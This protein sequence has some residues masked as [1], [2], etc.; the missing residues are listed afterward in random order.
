MA[1]FPGAQRPAARV[2]AVGDVSGRTLR[3]VDDPAHAPAADPATD[4]V[5][6]DTSWTPGPGDRPDVVSVR[7]VLTAVLRRADVI[8]GSLALLDA[9][10]ES[11]RLADRFVADDVTWWYR[12]RMM[13]RWDIHELMLWRLVL[14]ELGP[15]DRYDEIVV[16]P[17]RPALAAAAR[18]TGRAVEPTAGPRV[19]HG[20]GRPGSA[21][22]VDPSCCAAAGR[23]AAPTVAPS[24][25][26][27]R[28]LAAVGRASRRA[29]RRPD[30]GPQR[31]ARRRPRRRLGAVLPGHPIGWPRSVRR[32][33]SRP[34]AGPAGRRRQAGGHRRARPRSA[35][36]GRLAARGGRRSSPPE[37]ALVTALVGTRRRC[38]RLVRGRGED[39][40]S[41]AHP[42]RGRRLGPRPGGRCDR[43]RVRR[44]LARWPAARDP[45]RRA[46]HAGAPA[47]RPVHRPRRRPDVVAGRGAAAGHPDRGRPARC[48]LPRQ[49]GVLPSAPPGAGPAGDDLPVR[50]VR[51][52]PAGRAW[53]LRSG[54]GR[55]DRLL[56]RGSANGRARARPGRARAGPARARG[57]RRPAA[58]GRV[59]RAQ[60]DRRPA[61]Q[62]RDGRPAA[63]RSAARDP[64]RDQAASAG[65]DPG[66]V[67]GAPARAGPGRR[68]SPTRP[69][70]RPGR[71]PVPAAALGRRAPR[72]VFD[73]AHRRDRGRDAEH[74]RGRPG[75]ERPA[76]LRGRARR[77]AGRVRRRR[78]CLHARSEAR[79]SGRPVEV[80]RGALRAGGRDGPDRRGDPCRRG[81]RATGRRAAD[82][83]R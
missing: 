17:S 60:P 16:P 4:I 43:V 47:G 41:R 22:R 52:R 46:A 26:R 27:C 34:R 58:A 83:R 20:I 78:V 25:A 8:D 68:L 3:F 31:R 50:V 57:R 73:G 70:G 55:G 65:P 82:D 32:S 13:V 54:L 69:D 44:A 48:H 71:R 19:G 75:L 12:V 38:D 45:P 40:R 1:D 35:S 11:A 79:R 5:V 18:A 77:G 66:T 67:R 30:R 14:D 62:R 51:A 15:P 36:R 63:R 56:A 49:S 7:P 24:G 80:P 10:A 29:A 64:R 28:A 81:V 2:A 21:R 76:R 61:P 33:A 9:W 42:A 6:L 72:P 23:T 59:G 37:L 39:G 74:D 53:R